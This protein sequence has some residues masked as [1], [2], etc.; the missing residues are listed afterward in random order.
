MRNLAIPSFD[1]V[2]LE[3]RLQLR[4]LVCVL[5]YNN[6]LCYYMYSNTQNAVTLADGGI[7]L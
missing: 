1:M 3:P 2:I 5:M 7:V 6:A 4:K